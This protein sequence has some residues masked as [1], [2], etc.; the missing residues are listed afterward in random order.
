[1]GNVDDNGRIQ[2]RVAKNS[3]IECMVQTTVPVVPNQCVIYSDWNQHPASFEFFL[4]IMSKQV[5][6]G[7]FL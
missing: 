2:N 1:M 6:T 3:S 5:E 7:F 4:F